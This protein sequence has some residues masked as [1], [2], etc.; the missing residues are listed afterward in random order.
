MECGD[1]AVYQPLLAPVH[2]RQGVCTGLP[3]QSVTL[4]ALAEREPPS[5]HES[6]QQRQDE[7]EV[8]CERGPE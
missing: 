8:D 3:S 2:L 7:R 6:K 1:K 4:V 5:P